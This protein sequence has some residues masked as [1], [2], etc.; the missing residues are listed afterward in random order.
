M[1]LVLYGLS[2][3][4]DVSAR[5]LVGP[6]EVLG[7][8]H[9]PKKTEHY[10]EDRYEVPESAQARMGGIQ[11]RAVFTNN[12]EVPLFHAGCLTRAQH[13]QEKINRDEDKKTRAIDS[14]NAAIGDP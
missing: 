2:D 13:E 11:G 7:V 12:G 8:N 14:G 4:L 6:G 10:G 5:Y 9:G 1:H 3:L